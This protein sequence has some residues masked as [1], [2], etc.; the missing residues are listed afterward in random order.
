MRCFFI[1]FSL[2]DKKDCGIMAGRGV[3]R[4]DRGYATAADEYA[5]A[6]FLSLSLWRSRHQAVV[7]CSCSTQNVALHPLVSQEW[8]KGIVSALEFPNVEDPRDFEKHHHMHEIA[9]TVA[10]R[11]T[12]LKVREEIQWGHGQIQQGPA[13]DH[14]R[15]CGALLF[16]SFSDEKQTQQNCPAV[17]RKPFGQ[18]GK[19]GLPEPMPGALL[20]SS[21]IA[22]FV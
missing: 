7:R 17:A 3:G 11:M 10:R 19:R 16:A 18:I 20:S 13:F 2:V 1:R 21:P 6:L 12:F 14:A 4:G 15:S 5:E 22:V 9:A 8:K